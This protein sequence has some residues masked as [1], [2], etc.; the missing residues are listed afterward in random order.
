MR[1]SRTLIGFKMNMIMLLRRKVV[2]LLLTIIPCLFIAVVRLTS[3]EREVFFQLGVSQSEELVK[4]I[5]VNVA[6][7]FV[8]LATIGFLASFLSLNLVQEY[9]SI[10]RRLVICGFHPG[11]LVFSNLTVM[12]SM[13]VVLVLSV[14]AVILYFFNPINASQLLLGM[15]LMGITYGSYGLMVGSLIKGTLE[16]TL[17]VVLLANI[18]AGWIQ[19]P[20]YFSGAR[21]KFI[22]ELLP[23]YYPS[24][25]SIASAFTEQPTR[26]TMILSFVY[27]LF[28][29]GMATLISYYKMNIKT[30]K[31]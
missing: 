3:S 21:N 9:Q 19:N 18:D 29:L 2:I 22:I 10:N 24:Q 13:I 30:Y 7:V 16:G 11:E 27:M 4:G 25:L 15:L 26:H 1:L 6:L 28:F 5:E 17:S 12:L 14:W 20:L 31:G 8:S 23:A